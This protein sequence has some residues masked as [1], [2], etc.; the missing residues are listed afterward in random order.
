MESFSKSRNQFCHESGHYVHMYREEL[1]PL[2]TRRPG[3]AIFANWGIVYF[4][5]LNHRHRPN[6]L[7]TFFDVK[8]H[9]I[10]FSKKKR[11]GLHFG[12]FFY[13]LIRSPWGRCYDHNFLRFLPIFGEKIGV[14]SKNQC[15]DQ[16]FSKFVLSQKR[17]FFSP[18][19]SAKI[20]LKS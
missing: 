11:V 18:N 4:G 7:A 10:I 14:F 16:L 17:Q 13:K 5:Q 3:W 6:F 12:R 19:F 20:F 8:M 1:K 2:V 15:C 9:V